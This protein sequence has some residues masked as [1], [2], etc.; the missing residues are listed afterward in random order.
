MGRHQ[1]TCLALALTLLF[2]CS[3]STNGGGGGG[4]S[5]GAGGDGGTGGAGGTGGVV[6]TECEGDV[7]DEIA[8]PT[9]ESDTG[10]EPQ[11]PEG[12]Y[13]SVE[14]PPRPESCGAEYGYVAKVLGWIVAPGGK[15]LPGAYAQV[16]IYAA[17]GTYVCLNPSEADEEGV[18]EI[19]VPEFVRCVDSVAMRA[20]LPNSPRAVVYCPFAPGDEPVT[21]LED[22]LVLPF[23]PLAAELPAMSEEETREVALPDGLRLEVSPSLLPYGCEDY[24]RLGGRRIPTDAVGLCGEAPQL[25]GLYAFRPEG[26]VFDP[27]FAFTLE[28]ASGLPAGARVELLVLGGLATSLRDGTAVPEGEWVVFGEGQVSEDGTTIVPD[29][30]VTLPFLTWLGY[31]LKD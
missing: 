7:G 9:D 27:G 14:V 24:A 15:P 18:F 6:P 4:G 20:S 17:S 12:V 16:C 31:R 30:G 22:P 25:D 5:G 23:L 28:N 8:V 11:V 26:T 1:T 21:R 3:A 13:R 29:E 2:A 19:D 10:W